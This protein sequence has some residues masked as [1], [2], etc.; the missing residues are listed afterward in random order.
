MS[1]H[2]T[3]LN[4]DGAMSSET[5]TPASLMNLPTE[6]Q[7][8]IISFV[9]PSQPLASLN[10]TCKKFHDLTRDSLYH[11]VLIVNG[12]AE[13]FAQ[14]ILSKPERKE[15]VREV[16]VD[17]NIKKHE[18]DTDH[19]A[20][21]Y[22]PLFAEFINLKI[23]S[24]HSGYWHWDDP[25]DADYPD[26]SEYKKGWV[27]WETDQDKLTKSFENAGI[28]KPVEERIWQKLRSC[29]LDLTENN[30]QGWYCTFEP[31]I[32]LVAS[33]RELTLK[34]CRFT[35]RDGKDLLDSP[36]RGQTV[37][38]KLN[39]ER[40]YI[41][42]KAVF[43]FLS[44]PK[45]LTHLA[46]AHDCSLW[47]HEMGMQPST[48]SKAQEYVDAFAQQRHSLTVLRFNEEMC[49]EI[50]DGT[51]DLRDFPALRKMECSPNPMVPVLVVPGVVGVG[52]CADTRKG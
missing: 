11:S 3:S 40:S 17:C 50:Y 29:T 37:L 22:A 24:L 41:H 20:C 27:R 14:A 26:D 31:A 43:N 1:P 46:L 28:A 51:F 44:A 34:G 4:S 23:L 33:L 47:H 9:Q 5:E 15:L 6:L 36:F 19:S 8:H 45:A 2:T 16:V 30:G 49:D 25:F 42:H 7:E 13:A 39:L 38:Q 10:E 48:S 12:K 32:F 21:T 35:D 18:D 52:S